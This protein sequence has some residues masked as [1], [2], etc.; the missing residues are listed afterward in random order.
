MERKFGI[1]LEC[2]KN[3][4]LSSETVLTIIKEAG[5]DSV[6]SNEFDMA[7]VTEI[8]EKANALGIDVEFL[9]AP[10]RGVND[11]WCAGLDY[12][13]LKKNI[14]A[15]ID[16]AAANAIPVVVMHVD[17][18]WNPPKI[19]D[20]GLNR[21]DELVEYADKKGIK[22]AFENI[23]N[24]GTLSAMMQRYRDVGCVGYCYDCGHEHCY[25][26]TVR[27]TDLFG[28]KIL[29]THI[30]DNV[31]KDGRP[32][33]DDHLMMFDGNIDYADMMARLRAVEY[34]GTLTVE[35]EKNERYDHM[36]EKEYVKTAYERIVKISKL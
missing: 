27:F 18:G 36:S 23:R 31:G 9:H 25:T 11:F 10:F 32:D 4:D 7:K 26:K 3:S 22:L 16:S 12:L 21:F 28:D 35:I 19:C 15:S 20:T 14:I 6:F 13:P 33:P 5:F 29:C 1:E 17:S 24:F 34:T 8:K 30:H 2:L